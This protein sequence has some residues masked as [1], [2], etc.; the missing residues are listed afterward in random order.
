MRIDLHIHSTASD[1]AA[2]PADVVRRARAGGL[3]LISIT[4]HDTTSGVEP[5]RARADELGLTL[6]PGCE[7]S[8]THE[9]REVHVLGYGVDPDAGAL[10]SYE[11]RAL[12]RRRERMSVMIGHLA[13]LGLP[14]AFERVLEVAGGLGV[15]GRPHLARVLVEVGHARDLS[16]A[17]DRLIG[18]GS[19]AF[20][21]TQ[22]HSPTEA[23]ATIVASGGLPVWAHPPPDLV[24]RLLPDLVKAGLRGLEIYRP[25]NTPGYT[26]RLLERARAATLLASGGSD[27]HDPERHPALGT[28][29]VGVDQVGALLDALPT[30]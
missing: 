8:S 17:F 14:V 25:G 29:S 7:L 27:W 19:P 11:R 3:D 24:D 5:A 28:F 4:D 16:D 20:E 13:A 10:R 26:R 21:P 9:G 22:L 30:R 23:V 12:E 15:V 18:D 6:I 2:E 1:G